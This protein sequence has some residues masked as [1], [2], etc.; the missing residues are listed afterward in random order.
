MATDPLTAMVVN[1]PARFD[2]RTMSIEA[3]LGRPDRA[4]H[5]LQYQMAYLANRRGITVLPDVADS[6]ERLRN[7]GIEH[8]L[9]F[10]ELVH[11]VLNQ[12]REGTETEGLD[13]VSRPGDEA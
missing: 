6:F 2:G 1:V 5:P 7:I 9:V 13:G 3:F 4:N 10:T 8:N 12:I 11:Y